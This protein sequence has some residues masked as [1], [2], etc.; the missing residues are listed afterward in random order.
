MAGVGSSAPLASPRQSR[1]Y[2]LGAADMDYY[3]GT[4]C[5]CIV[6][7][8]WDYGI[9][10]DSVHNI[11]RRPG[12]DLPRFV[13]ATKG[14]E[15]RGVHIDYFLNE[16][17][18]SFILLLDSDMVF[19]PDT[20]ERLRTFGRPYVS[21]FYMRR[22]ADFLAPIWFEYPESESQWP[23]TPYTADPERGRLH[24]IGASGW[25]CVLIHRAVFEA[26]QPHLKGEAFVIEDDMDIWPYDLSAVM[27]ALHKGDLDTLRQEIRPL[28]GCKDN[29]GSDL[30]FPFFA[31]QAGFDLYGDPDTRPGHVVNYPLSP[32]DYTNTP[33]ET[34]QAIAESMLPQLE[35]ER[36]KVQTAVAQLM[37]VAL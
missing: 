7:P 33:I 14:F 24:K 23:L 34:R 26:M 5:T 18:H 15:A 31:R 13:R 8:D 3:S 30:R 4:V 28:R 27:S 37:G 29:I 32:N 17:D 35:E 6:G 2:N 21:G 1:F 22:R 20:L 12:D 9:C 25:G 11:N 10:R 16:T 36:I 19:A